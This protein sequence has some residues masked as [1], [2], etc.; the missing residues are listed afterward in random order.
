MS[1]TEN[2]VDYVINAHSDTLPQEVSE[3]AKTF[4][5]DTLGCAIRILYRAGKR[6]CGPGKGI[7]WC[8]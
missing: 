2:L 6:D 5:L 1:Y 7:Q 8:R 3:Q 4:I